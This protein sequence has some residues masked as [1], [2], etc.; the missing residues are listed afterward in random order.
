MRTLSNQLL[1]VR[2]QP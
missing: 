2:L 1:E